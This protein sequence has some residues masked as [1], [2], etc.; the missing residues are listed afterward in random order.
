[1]HY[2]ATE[3]IYIVKTTKISNL[4]GDRICR[5]FCKSVFLYCIKSLICI[6]YYYVDLFQCRYC[7]IC[8]VL[9]L[10]FLNSG[11]LI[12]NKTKRWEY[13]VTISRSINLK[14]V[15]VILRNLYLS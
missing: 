12:M 3:T 5:H 9:L 8:S 6:M 15:R 10:L 13:Q 1:M 11:K 4:H 7:N 14:V 2:Q